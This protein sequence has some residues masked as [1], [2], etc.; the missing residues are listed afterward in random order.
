MPLDETVRIMA[1]LDEVRSL[2]G[3]RYPDESGL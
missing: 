1:T 2:L 3:V